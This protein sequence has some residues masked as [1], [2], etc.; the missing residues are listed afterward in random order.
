MEIFDIQDEFV[1]PDTSVKRHIQSMGSGYKI[2]DS[3]DN[4]CSE[5][6]DSR[7]HGCDGFIHTYRLREPI[8]QIDEKVEHWYATKLFIVDIF[9]EDTYVWEREEAYIG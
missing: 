3:I 2:Y 9:N 4:L 1:L 7:P 5:H 8:L 6:I